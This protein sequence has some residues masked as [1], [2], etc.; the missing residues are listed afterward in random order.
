MT[1][2]VDTLQESINKGNTL[3]FINDDTE[4]NCFNTSIDKQLYK[5]LLDKCLKSGVKSIKNEYKWYRNNNLIFD[6]KVYSINEEFINLYKINNYNLIMTKKIIK[7]HNNESF[8]GLLYYDQED[9][10][11]DNYYNFNGN[12]IHFKI[13]N[14]NTYECSINI[15]NPNNIKTILNLLS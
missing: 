2:Y 14:H 1:E 3:T 6:K 9:F 13:I 15:N 8:P 4:I 11:I 10:I 12:K 7:N 5:S